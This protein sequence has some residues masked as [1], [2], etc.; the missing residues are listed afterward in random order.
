MPVSGRK[1][2]EKSQLEK[3]SEL[4]SI[5]FLHVEALL[6]MRPSLPRRVSFSFF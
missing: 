3:K 4:K 5:P 6:V 1:L 2:N